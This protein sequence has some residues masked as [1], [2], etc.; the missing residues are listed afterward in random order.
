MQVETDLP[1]LTKSD[2]PSGLSQVFMI[3]LVAVTA[4]EK[5]TL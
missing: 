1:S 4:S 5:L 2:I 3:Y